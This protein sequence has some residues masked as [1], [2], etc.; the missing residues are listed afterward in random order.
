MRVRH[1]LAVL[2]GLAGVFGLPAAAATLTVTSVADSGPGSLRAQLAAAAANDTIVFDPSL[3][4]QTIALTSGELVIP[5]SVTIQGPGARQLAITNTTGRIF[6]TL[7]NVAKTV[8][9]D[10]VTLRNANAAGNGGAIWNRAG[11]LVL[12]NAAL[13][14]NTA[15]GE[16][17]AIFN[18]TFD[19]PPGTSNSQLTIENSLIAG[20]SANKA[21]AIRFAGFELQIANSTISGNSATDSVGGLKLEFAFATIRNSTIVGNSAGLSVGGIEAN[22]PFG[23]VTFE[24]TVVANNT[25]SSGINDINRLSGGTINATRSLFSESAATM[26]PQPVINGTDSGNQI[27]VPAQLGALANNGGPTDTHRP[28]PS[29]PLLGNGSNSQ[30]FPFDQRGPGFPRNFGPN[31]AVDIGAIQRGIDVV[32]GVPS[33]SLG[34]VAALAALLL[35]AT[36]WRRRARR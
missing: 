22:L 36:G 18:E 31:D 16:G 27:G 28:G 3:N 14:G 29:S 23:I 15:S 17:G 35:V 11:N 7:E 19:S 32:M 24:S 21:G 25:D 9:I 30:G 10:G 2:A 8:V 34:G 5:V 26:N 13:L 20:N 1:L 12:R 6:R 4:G 33:M